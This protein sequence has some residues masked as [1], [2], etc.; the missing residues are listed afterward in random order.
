MFFIK[1]YDGF[2]VTEV[3]VVLCFIIIMI[4]M[5]RPAL[6]SFSASI[7]MHTTAKTIKSELMLAKTRALGDPNVHAGV[8]FD[9]AGSPDCV[10]AFMDDDTTSM[11]DYQ[12]TQGKDHLLCPPYKLPNYDTLRILSS[13][14]FRTVV[15][16][17]DGS[18]KTS[19][20][21]YISNKL[22]RGDT[23]TV[24]ASTG[25]IRLMRKK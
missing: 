11:N 8:Y 4:F 17:G 12:Y 16:R 25:R 13:S 24:L 20:R 18:A 3:M 5:A 19:A 6:K 7:G 23:L 14:P 22:K 15:F 10:V 9:T 21:I 2:T 1:K